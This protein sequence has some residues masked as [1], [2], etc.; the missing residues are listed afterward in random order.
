M[1]TPLALLTFHGMGRQ[2]EAF[3][4]PLRERLARELGG[5]VFAR[6]AFEGVHY[7]PVIEPRQ[8]GTWRAMRAAAR[9]DWRELRRFVLFYLSDVATYQY[10]PGEAGSVYRAVHGR[11]REALARLRTRVGAGEPGGAPV[12]AV[13]H[14][15]GCAVL[16]DYLWDAQRGRGIFAGREVEPWERMAGLRLL[17]TTGCNIPL[18]VAG[19]ERI[20]AIDPPGPEFAWWNLYDR[21][22]PL[23][24]PLRPLSTGFANAYDRVVTGDVEVSVGL[25]P[26]GHS[27][28]WEDRDVARFVAGKVVEVMGEGENR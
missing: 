11:I 18:F 3:D 14:S 27:H 6:I 19:L 7:Q 8:E 12:V 25:T 22:D 9:L 4:A 26:L 13:A 5:D 2:E 23:G 21:D 10:R 15:F 28:Y 24:W 16:S 1:T 17:V 20:E